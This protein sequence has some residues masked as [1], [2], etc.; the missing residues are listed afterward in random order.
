VT[1]AIL[2]TCKWQCRYCRN[3]K[4]KITEY[5]LEKSFKELKKSAKCGGDSSDD[6]MMEQEADRIFRQHES[7]L[8]RKARKAKNQGQIDLD[9]LA[10]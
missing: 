2:H 3:K 8:K 10:G 7:T 5:N 4:Y 9:S 6:E 1:F